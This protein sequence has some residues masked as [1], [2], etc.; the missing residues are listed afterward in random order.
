MLMAGVAVSVVSQ[1]F[2]CTR[3][4]IHKLMTRYVHTG[5]VR[6]RQRLGRPRA[7]TVRTDRF[8]TLTHVNSFCRRRS[9]PD[10]M[11]YLSKR[12]VTV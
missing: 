11:D 3:H 9:L 12:S 1:A 10:V 8:I 6:D 4:A 5:Q 7:T 2:G